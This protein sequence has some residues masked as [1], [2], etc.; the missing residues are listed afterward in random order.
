MAVTSN[1]LE[2]VI[3][4]LLEENYWRIYFQLGL[5]LINPKLALVMSMS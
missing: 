3:M 5:F 4:L 2:D 1:I